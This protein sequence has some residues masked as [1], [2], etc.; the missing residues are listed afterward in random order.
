MHLRELL[1]IIASE[2]SSALPQDAHGARLVR[3]AKEHLA[4]YVPTGYLIKG[5]SGQG[6]V[7]SVPWIGIFDPDETDSATRGMYVVYLFAADMKTVY[8]SLI[9]G[10][11]NLRK[12]VKRRAL[13]QLA[14]QAHVIREELAPELRVGTSDAI[15][16]LAP[17]TIVRPRYYEA[18]T[19]VAKSYAVNALPSD[20]ILRDD[21]NKFLQLCQH[22]LD[23]RRRLAVSRPESIATREEFRP[24]A[25]F[26]PFKPKSDTD[27]QQKIKARTVN[28]SRKHETLVNRFNAHLTSL[29]YSTSSPHPRDLTALRAG[30]HWLVEAKV[31]SRG[32]GQR[33][34]REALAQLVEYRYF[35]EPHDARMLAL[36]NEPVGEAFVELLETVDIA[37][38]WPDGDGWTGSPKAL[39]AGLC[40]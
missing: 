12:E 35:Y 13:E 38:A 34:A 28:K 26:G 21:L 25:Q 5:S 33:A 37:S 22:A 24:P 29:G 3:S 15:E 23:I 17:P 8:L 6:T 1:R 9:Q 18:G 16:L 10:T 7:A 30:Q 39:L 11:E 14:A 2:Y 20:A 4:P 27:Y 40:G 32:N 36:F 19:I 31:V